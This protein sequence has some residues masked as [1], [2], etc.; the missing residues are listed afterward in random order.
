MQINVVRTGCC[1]DA[2]GS[3][4]I[5]L[6]G[7]ASLV[8]GGEEGKCELVLI[9]LYPRSRVIFIFSLPK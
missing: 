5:G 3:A 6:G 7:L 4:V 1:R 2:H 9:Y 8:G